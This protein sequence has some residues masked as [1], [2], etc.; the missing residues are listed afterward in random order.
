MIGIMQPY[1]FPYIGYFQ[2]IDSVDTYVNLD[3]VAFM[4][5]SYMTRNIINGQPIRIE[6]KSGSQNKKCNEVF[7]NL[8]EKNIKK[9]KKTIEMLYSKS[10]YYND[11]T[12]I[13]FP[14]F[15]NFNQTISKFNLE[16]IKS[17]CNYLDITTKIV[18]TSEGI[19]DL[20]REFG[21]IDIT[22][23]FNETTYVNA[24]GGKKLYSK[25]VFKENGIDLKFIE[26]GD[27]KFDNKYASILDLL[28]KYDKEYIKKELKKYE[29]S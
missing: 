28:F 1:F 25:E 15:D 6:I 23:K 24:I 20:K 8:N 21:L 4:K 2:L 18:N 14:I 26:M 3:H 9:F 7:V 11:I 12:N 17:I 16:I 10:I 29:I 13:I 27:V 5:R 19:T 22:K